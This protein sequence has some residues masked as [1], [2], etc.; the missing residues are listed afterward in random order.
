MLTRKII[1]DGYPITDTWEPK[2]GAQ[3]GALVLI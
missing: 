3:A 1:N 2:S